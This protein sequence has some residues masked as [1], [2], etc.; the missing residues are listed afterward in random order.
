MGEIVAGAALE[1]L[2]Q[3]IR[4]QATQAE[5]PGFVVANT[6][7]ISRREVVRTLVLLPPQKLAKD[8]S[9]VDSNDQVLPTHVLKMWPITSRSNYVLPEAFMQLG[10][11]SGA[12]LLLHEEKRVRLLE[13]F[14]AHRLTPQRKETPWYIAEVEF[15][16][17]ELMPASYRTFTFRPTVSLAFNKPRKK[18]AKRNAPITAE[19]P[20]VRVKGNVVENAFLRAKFFPDGS[21][22]LFDKIGSR[23]FRRC[24][25]F[26]DAEDVGDEYDYAPAA[27]R[28]VVWSRGKKGKLR[29]AHQ[30]TIAA[31]IEVNLE[32]PLPV[33][34]DRD[35]NRRSTKTIRCPVQ[36]RFTITATTPYIAVRTT[37]QNLARDHRLRVRFGTP[38]TT[39][40]SLAGQQFYVIE[41]PLQKPSGKN[42]LQPPSPTEPMQY[43]CAI[44][45]RKGGLA[46]LTRGLYEYEARREGK[47][48]A[49]FLTLLRA[50]GWLSRNDLATRPGHAGPAIPTPEA[51]CPGI[52]E[53]HYAVAPYVG[54]WEKA[55]LPALAQRYRV[56]LLEKP[57]RDAAGTLPVEFSLFRLEPD[58]LIVTAIK[59][60]ESRDTTI[61]RLYNASSQRVRGKLFWGMPLGHAWKVNLLEERLEETSVFANSRVDLD[62]PAW[63]ILTLELETSKSVLGT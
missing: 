59:K 10:N 6:I 3:R 29:V 2:A 28:Q 41:R 27:K 38:I 24:H 9:V 37:F 8:F 63:R 16:T 14:A 4:R 19:P 11:Y 25:V 47:G 48:A 34:F 40:T 58:S 56:P 51:Q 7:A 54:S 52:H 57:C 12:H 42:W 55:N 31:E 61:V 43:F 46:L 13:E 35:R 15:L 20:T 26:E 45:N 44:E 1:T 39:K 62:V 32:L 5:W 23:P 21:F 53:F 36:I 49:L 18:A 33:E 22:D 30:S 17:P 50:V 60:C